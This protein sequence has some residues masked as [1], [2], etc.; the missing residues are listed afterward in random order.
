MTVLSHKHL[1][2]FHLVLL[3]CSCL[4]QPPYCEEAQRAVIKDP[5][6]RRTKTSSPQLHS[7]PASPCEWAPCKVDLLPPV[8]QL[9]WHC[10]EQSQVIPTKVSPNC[11]WIHVYC[12]LSVSPHPQQVVSGDKHFWLCSFSTLHP[13]NSTFLYSRCSISVSWVIAWMD[14][15]LWASVLQT[16]LWTQLR[17]TSTSN[18][19]SSTAVF[20][21]RLDMILRRPLHLPWHVSPGPWKLFFPLL[22]TYPG[23]Q[24]QE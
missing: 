12:L 14:E 5:M 1:T 13:S 22:D 11:R 7:A 24:M 19:S 8:D 6:W 16:R 17:P 9:N 3:E 10:V 23:L 15:C 20:P 18:S 21:N 4:T 2:H